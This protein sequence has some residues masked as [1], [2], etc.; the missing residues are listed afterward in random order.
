MGA[1]PADRARWMAGG[2]G[3]AYTLG[4][5]FWWEL[6][7]GPAWPTGRGS[8]DDQRP[9]PGAD[10]GSSQA[11]VRV[12]ASGDAPSRKSRADCPVRPEKAPAGV[13]M[14]AKTQTRAAA[15]AHCATLLT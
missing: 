10:E 1:K 7:G 2:D 12:H 8:A 13:R 14:L 11:S 4:L 9:R 5:S 15:S 6:G 3:A